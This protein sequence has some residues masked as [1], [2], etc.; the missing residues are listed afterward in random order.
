MINNNIN[1]IDKATDRLVKKW[2]HED[3]PKD[4]DDCLICGENFPM[5]PH[6]SIALGCYTHQ[7]IW[8]NRQNFLRSGYKRSIYD[9]D[10]EF[11]SKIKNI[12]DLIH[13]T[14]AMEIYKTLFSRIDQTFKK[15]KK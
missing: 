4:T 11:W 2:K 7:E 15:T 3:P 10:E 8:T 13:N 5:M 1:I 12:D 14:C 9:D 6:S